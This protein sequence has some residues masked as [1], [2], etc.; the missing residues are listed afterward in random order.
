MQDI[1]NSSGYPHD[2]STETRAIV[3]TAKKR[4]E[5]FLKPLTEY[6]NHVGLDITTQ[7]GWPETRTKQKVVPFVAIFLLF[8]SIL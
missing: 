1:F 2:K 5:G 3:T 7:L 4:M 6:Y 8:R